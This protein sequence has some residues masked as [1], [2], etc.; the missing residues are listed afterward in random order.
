MGRA[1]QA[2]ERAARAHR[3]RA[4]LHEL[5]EELRAVPPE[6]LVDLLAAPPGAGAAGPFPLARSWLDALRAG[7]ARRQAEGRAPFQPR[8]LRTTPWAGA[9]R[10][11]ARVP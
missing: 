8:R 7:H 5:E 11:A 10:R 9:E 1:G 4:L 6:A 3:V 2:A